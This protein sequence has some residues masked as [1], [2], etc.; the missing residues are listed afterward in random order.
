MPAHLRPAL[1]R[2]IAGIPAPWLLPPKSGEAFKDKAHYMKRLQAFALSQG[3]A[4]ITT[5][6]DNQRAIFRCIHHREETRNY[7]QER[8]GRAKAAK[9]LGHL[10]RQRTQ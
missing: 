7:C 8:L 2:A 9:A 3:F 1:D 4:V 5:K 10:S 6:S